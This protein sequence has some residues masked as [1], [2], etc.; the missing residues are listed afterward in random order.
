MRGTQP[1]VDF[2]I[3]LQNFRCGEFNN[4][5]ALYDSIGRYF[6]N[7]HVTQSVVCP[8]SL[9]KQKFWLLFENPHNILVWLLNNTI[10]YNRSHFSL[11]NFSPLFWCSTP[12]F[13]IAI[14]SF[15]CLPGKKIEVHKAEFIVKPFACPSENKDIS[16]SRDLIPPANNSSWNQSDVEPRPDDKQCSEIRFPN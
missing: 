5:P 7:E 15:R 12:C 9:D 8:E 14:M 10:I 2:L 1:S 11:P 16:F 6:S 13:W 4:S 3:D